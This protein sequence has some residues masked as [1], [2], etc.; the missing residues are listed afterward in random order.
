[1]AGGCPS[2]ELLPSEKENREG[3]HSETKDSFKMCIARYD[4]YYAGRCI[5]RSINGCLRAVDLDK[6]VKG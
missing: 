6:G 1:M 5:A 3:E 2:R 4:D